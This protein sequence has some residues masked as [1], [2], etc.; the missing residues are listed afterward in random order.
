MLLLE[1]SYIATCGIELF[2][3]SEVI[4]FVCAA[5]MGN[6]PLCISQQAVD[7]VFLGENDSH[8]PQPA[9]RCL[10]GSPNL[11]SRLIIE[12]A[13]EGERG[14]E[15]VGAWDGWSEDVEGER[16]EEGEC[17]MILG[18]ELFQDSVSDCYYM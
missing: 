8:Q 6:A 1:Y 12:G 14:R 10:S 16:G 15:E 9:L 11:H 4:K 5:V 7:G 3:T 2:A 17:D 13:G 18:L